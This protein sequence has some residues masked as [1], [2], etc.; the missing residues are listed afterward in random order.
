MQQL[1]IKRGDTLYVE[2]QLVDEFGAGQSLSGIHVQ[3]KLLD[4]GGN[5]AHSFGITTIFE[6]QGK[7]ALAEFN[8]GSIPKAL[9]TL[10]ISYI[11]NGATMSNT[12]FELNVCK[13]MGKEPVRFAQLVSVIGNTRVL[14]TAPSAPSG[15]LV[16]NEAWDELWVN[17]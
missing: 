10:E 16:W 4:R 5:E 6:S 15:N 1:T 11:R 12:A 8:T 17:N 9:Y 2:C 3:A 14:I 13:Q 7:Y